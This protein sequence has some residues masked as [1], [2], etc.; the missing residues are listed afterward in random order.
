MS[1]RPTWVM[2]A[3]HYRRA[4]FLLGHMK[5]LQPF[6]TPQA[7]ARIRYSHK[8]PRC[9]SWRVVVDGGLCY[10]MLCYAMLCYAMLCYAML[11]YAMLCY[12]MLCY[13]ML[14]YAMLC[15]PASVA[16]CS[17]GAVTAQ[18]RLLALNYELFM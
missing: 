15:A 11:C 3:M 18:L 9:C 13:A 6:I 14:C 1:Q 2:Q 12:A 4:Q 17:S 10:A 8:A 5:V 7:A 16:L